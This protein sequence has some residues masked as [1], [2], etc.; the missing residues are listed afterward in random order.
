MTWYRHNIILSDRSPKQRNF[1]FGLRQNHV[2]VVSALVLLQ[3]HHF[4]GDINLHIGKS[5]SLIRPKRAILFEL[6]DI[7]CLAWWMIAYCYLWCGICNGTNVETT[8][9]LHDYT[10]YTVLVL[11]RLKK[12]NATAWQPQRNVLMYF[13]IFKNVAHSLEPGETPS[14]SASHK[15]PN[16]VQCS[17]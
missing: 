11:S 9:Y 17:F 3:V 12:I 10:L 8:S 13:A 4:S 14:Y 6:Y 15:A 1:V 5:H 7:N 16:Y 2:R